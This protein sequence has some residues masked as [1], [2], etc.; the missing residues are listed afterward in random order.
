[1]IKILKNNTAGTLNILDRAVLTGESYNVSPNY[2]LKLSD[3]VKD[4]GSSLV[5]LINDG[6]VIVNDSFADLSPELGIRHLFRITPA[7][8]VTITFIHAGHPLDAAVISYTELLD[9]WILIPVKSVWKSWTWINDLTGRTFE[10]NFYKN[11]L[12][13]GDIIHNYSVTDSSTIGGFE[14]NVNIVLEVG[15]LIKIRHL[16]GV[17]A[18]ENMVCIFYVE[19]F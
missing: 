10:L 17:T 15:D 4:S 14:N 3:I 5:G 12:A 11:G 6:D 19:V 9:Q 7:P 18:P 16:G 8:V 2:Y 13:S 1:M